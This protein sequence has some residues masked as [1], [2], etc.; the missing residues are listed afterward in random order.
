M[1][2]AEALAPCWPNGANDEQWL[3]VPRVAA[4]DPQ[5]P[6]YWTLDTATNEWVQRQRDGTEIQRAP[7]RRKHE[8]T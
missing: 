8:H 6:L 3:A 5:T 4:A 2:G 7:T 1:S